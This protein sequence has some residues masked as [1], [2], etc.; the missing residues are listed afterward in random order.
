[1]RR[2]GTVQ[3]S[4]ARI[5]GWPRKAGEAGHDG[6][7]EGFDQRIARAL[8]R[9]RLNFYELIVFETLKPDRLKADAGVSLAGER[10]GGDVRAAVLQLVPCLAAGQLAGAWAQAGAVGA[11]CAAAAGRKAAFPGLGVAG[12]AGALSPA[13]REVQLGFRQAGLAQRA[14]VATAP[15]GR[16]LAG[17][18]AL[19]QPEP[20]IGDKPDRWALRAPCGLGRL[21]WCCAT[22]QLGLLLRVGCRG[23]VAAHGRL[24]GRGGGGGSRG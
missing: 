11:C 3:V 23:L 13:A 12:G 1:M 20:A 2:S 10:Q 21:P 17:G 18:T 19:L 5:G 14:R 4:V 7:F 22:G 9:P 16:R 15:P 8:L 6:R 24:R